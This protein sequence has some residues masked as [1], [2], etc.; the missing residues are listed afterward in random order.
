M[1]GSYEPLV[2]ARWSVD[3]HGE[4]RSDQYGD[5]YHSAEGALPQARHVFLGG[6]RL[7][8]RWRER[9]SFTV[10]ELGFGLGQNFLATWQAW[11]ADVARCRR[12]HYV[13]FEAHPFEEADLRRSCARLPADLQSH[14]AALLAGW[15][16]LLPGL[17]RIEFEG[18]ALTLTLALGRVE[19][20]A[21][22][23][24]AQVDAFYLDGFA[25]RVN[26]DMWTPRVF[27]QMRRLSVAGATVATWCAAGQVRRDLR[28]AGFLVSKVPGFA[29]KRDMTVAVLRPGL[30]SPLAE[31]AAGR[32]VAVIGSGLAGVGVAQSLALRGDAVELWDPG[33][34]AHP[35]VRDGPLAAGAL[36]PALSPDDDTRSRLS[37]VGLE[38]AR[39]RWMTLP[40]A[41][42]P[43]ACGALVCSRSADGA[44]EQERAMARLRFPPKWVRR[45]DAPEAL[46]QSGIVAPDGGLWFAQAL[47]VDFSPLV[48]ALRATPGVVTRPLQLVGLARLDRGGWALTD[49]SGKVC[50]EVD[51]VVLAAG[52]ATA[53][54]LSTVV[55]PDP[56][57]VL[58]T[59]QPIQ[60]QLSL[61]PVS[62]DQASIPRCIV[63][64]K[65][66]CL[67]PRGHWG[68]AGSTYWPR[69]GGEPSVQEGHRE[70]L[71]QLGGWLPQGEVPW[72]GTG[73]PQPWTSW[74][75]A[76]RDHLPVVGEVAG[77]A[78]LWLACAYGSR[79][80]TWSALAG[81]VIA[82][83]LHGEPAPLEREL[84]HRIRVR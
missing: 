37:R 10:C 27:G 46:A 17:H 14:A 50:S 29:A 60:G 21:P 32:R 30:G 61:Y 77:C 15:P 1:P 35:D 75:V 78:G 42:R 59:A 71:D 25:P 28:D 7:P 64:G 48:A 40:L 3:A 33:V 8:D 11:R 23:I 38:R 79:G 45:V 67:P 68:V 13:A 52:C 39:T 69:S 57:P 31:D 65:G 36:V 49:A 80:L 62:C 84:L 20:F 81:D 18:G 5:I 53:R 43:V 41:A 19:R 6:N 82:A 58:R 55:P 16:S 22:Q 70:I 73:S 9:E 54:L 63:A 74:R 12:L 2:P 66:Y 26:P 76:T 51:Q 56:W 47:R 4:P 83:S 24:Q 72:L 44:R 34:A